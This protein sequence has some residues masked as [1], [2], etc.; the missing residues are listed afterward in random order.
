MFQESM[1]IDGQQMDWVWKFSLHYWYISIPITIYL[2]WFIEI[3][4][5]TR[6]VTN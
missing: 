1:S 3:H 2:L 6:G 5:F 4:I